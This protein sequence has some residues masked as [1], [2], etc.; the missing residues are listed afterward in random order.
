MSYLFSI[1][2]FVPRTST[3]AMMIQID[4][5][6][7]HQI[8]GDKLRFFSFVR[9]IGKIITLDIFSIMK[10]CCF[11]PIIYK[12]NY[13]LV[14]LFPVGNCA[15]TGPVFLVTHLKSNIFGHNTFRIVWM[16]IYKKYNQFKVL[17][18][19]D[20]DRSYCERNKF[21]AITVCG[22]WSMFASV[23]WVTFVSDNVLCLFGGAMQISEPI[24]TCC[25]LDP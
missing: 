15:P 16:I 22:G 4:I 2:P 20:P 21:I 14:P 9:P 10:R 6:I 12:A 11:V 24:M 8:I 7:P 5:S 17:H 19:I 13:N 1:V 18:T 3:N 23:N 25:E